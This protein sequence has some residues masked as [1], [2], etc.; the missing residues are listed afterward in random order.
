MSIFELLSL[1]MYR[2]RG[3]TYTNYVSAVFVQVLRQDGLGHQRTA[4]VV[5]L[6]RPR[7]SLRTRWNFSSCQDE[8]HGVNLRNVV[9]QVKETVLMQVLLCTRNL[10]MRTC[11]SRNHVFENPIGKSGSPPGICAKLATSKEQKGV[12]GGSQS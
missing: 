12:G 7:T 5:F 9:V 2:G 11:R 1:Q 3:Y 4:E 6:C 10:L 8:T